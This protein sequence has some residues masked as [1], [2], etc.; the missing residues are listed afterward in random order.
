MKKT[1]QDE[2]MNFFYAMGKNNLPYRKEPLTEE[3]ISNLIV[4]YNSAS[5]QYYT[6]NKS[7][8]LK[9]EEKIVT[10]FEIFANISKGIDVIKCED[11]DLIM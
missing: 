7:S 2:L 4:V 5:K 3:E 10:P 9:P 8:I 6:L 1:T 11:D